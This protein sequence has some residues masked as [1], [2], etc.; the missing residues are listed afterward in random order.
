MH[1]VGRPIQKPGMRN[2]DCP[3]YDDCLS[4][5]AKKFWQNFSCSLCPN[6]SLKHFFDKSVIPDDYTSTSY[7][8]PPDIDQIVRE[9]DS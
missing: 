8:L 5:A 3:F 1:L 9:Y 2:I 6:K 7:G 4:H